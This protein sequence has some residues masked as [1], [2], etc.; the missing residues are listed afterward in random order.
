MREH[1]IEH[2]PVRGQRAEL[3]GAIG[4]AR[5]RHPAEVD[6][7]LHQFLFAELVKRGAE[8]IGKKGQQQHQVVGRIDGDGHVSFI[9]PAARH[10]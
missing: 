2:G 5:L 9:C 6:H 10:R 8:A 3:L 4:E 1:V 7:D